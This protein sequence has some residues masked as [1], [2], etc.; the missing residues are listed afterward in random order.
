MIG[1][2]IDE[3]VA[4][5]D[6]LPRYPEAAHRLMQVIGDEKSSIGQVVDI[7][8]YDQAV[9]TE[10]LKLCNSAAMGLT[11]KIT[12]IDEATGLLGTQTLLQLV[13][14]AHSRTLLSPPQ[15]GY[16]LAPGALWTH[17]IGVAFGAEAIA[18][19]RELEQHTVAFTAGLLHDMGKVILNEYVADVYADIVAAVARD[20]VTFVEAEREVLGITHAEVGARVAERW[21]LPHEI[22]RCIRY[23]HEPGA[24]EAPDPIVDSVHVADATCLL[25]GVGG[26][27]DGQLY[28][29]DPDALAR[30]DLRASGLEQLGAEIVGKLRSLQDLFGTQ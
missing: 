16:G 11:R 28:R 26:G 20:G 8:R 21:S 10:L 3:I 2:R 27:D 13:L 12:S 17:C 30:L 24:L 25:V 9:T 15:A 7:I 6:S 22:V 19:G 29:C 18:E 1:A 4:K 23:H 14:S 5:V